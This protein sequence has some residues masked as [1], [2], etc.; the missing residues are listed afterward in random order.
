MNAHVRSFCRLKG[1]KTRREV[2]S[3]SLNLVMLNLFPH[4][5][6]ALSPN[7]PPLTK[8]GHGP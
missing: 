8:S 2:K 7:A 3:G 5:W 6:P 4:P 1:I